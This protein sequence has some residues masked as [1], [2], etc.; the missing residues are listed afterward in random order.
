MNIDAKLLEKCSLLTDYEKDLVRRIDI[1]HETQASVAK[2]YGKSPATISIQ[3][4]RALGKFNAWLKGR[5]KEKVLPEE[6]FDKQVFKMLNKGI[7]PAEIVAKIGRAREVAKLAELWEQLN[8]HD[9]W[10]TI[11]LLRENDMFHRGY[12]IEKPLLYSAN[13]I[14]QNHYAL[15]NRVEG[16]EEVVN[17]LREENVRKDEQI[18]TSETLKEIFRIENEELLWLRKYEPLTDEQIQQR[19]ET[20]RKL[21]GEIGGLKS[22][23]LHLDLQVD[24][25]K[26]VVFDLHT[27]IRETVKEYLAAMEINEVWKFVID[28]KWRKTEPLMAQILKSTV[29]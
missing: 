24:R 3:H 5:E 26:C 23:R 8:S 14:V 2:S 25:A 6:D 16:L 10:Q 15:K 11:G 19:R 27:K 18:K 13:K 20:I 12:A 1:N 4:K 29:A 9:Y 22:L 28:A 7:G 21:D 17:I